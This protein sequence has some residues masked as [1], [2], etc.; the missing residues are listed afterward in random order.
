MGVK[1]WDRDSHIFARDE[2]DHYVEEAW[3]PLRLIEAEQ[4]RGTVY[5]PAVGIGRTRDACAML[6]IPFI[7]SDL[8]DRGGCS[9][10]M[11]GVDFLKTKRL[12]KGVRHLVF[13]GP[14]KLWRE[15]IEHALSLKPESVSALIA[16][17]RANAGHWIAGTPC[18]MEW[19]LTP[20]PSMPTLDVVKKG[21][22]G[23]GT[24]D[25]CYH[26]FRPGYAGP[27]Q[28][29]WLHRDKGAIR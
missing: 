5:D 19:K 25:F 2:H 23:G 13:N 9:K 24:K 18:V 22:V 29:G 15:F 12:P 16:V 1:K 11:G 4:L 6:G 17:P 26:V 14:F 10:G 8:I 21:K 3:C 28:F 7:G 20:R 27:R